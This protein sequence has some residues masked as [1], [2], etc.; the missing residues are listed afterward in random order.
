MQSLI[1][2]PFNRNSVGFEQSHVSEKPDCTFKLFIW[3]ADFQLN[4]WKAQTEI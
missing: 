4:L 3:N 1:V 2:K